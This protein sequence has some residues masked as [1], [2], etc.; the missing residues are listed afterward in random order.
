MQH[1]TMAGDKVNGEEPMK[2][3][4]FFMCACGKTV[5]WRQDEVGRTVVCPGCAARLRVPGSPGDGG[6]AP[7]PLPKRKKEGVTFVSLSRAAESP[8]VLV[9]LV[10]GLIIVAIAGMVCL[11]YSAVRDWTQDRRAR[12]EEAVPPIAVAPAVRPP[13]E[14][15][16]PRAGEGD[17]PAVG[18]RTAPKV[19]PAAPKREP[20]R[21]RT[22]L[23]GGHEADFQD[24]APE[25]GLL[26]GFRLWYGR[27]GPGKVLWGIEPTYQVG[28]KR[29]AGS[30]QGKSRGKA[31]VLMAK[32]G[33]VIESATAR[34]GHMVAGL[35][36]R[37][38]P[39]EAAGG[40]PYESAWH[41][42]EQGR[43]GERTLGGAG[44]RVVGIRGR[45]R[46][47]PG[48]KGALASLGLVIEERPEQK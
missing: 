16:G 33:Y 43:A 39:L 30:V 6:P 29:V 2:Q 45:V 11:F 26:C 23:V 37:F 41:G 42:G 28:D 40:K 4:R 47:R 9:F 14:G 1:W 19:S 34:G 5:R 22:E 18:K 38:V 46:E 27:C 32:P 20:R 12:V 31:D 13:K 24:L 10:A 44:C 48:F 35:R 3:A 36:V 21:T 7:P 8:R 15:Q 17:K 25:G